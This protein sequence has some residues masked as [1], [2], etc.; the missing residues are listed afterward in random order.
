MRHRHARP[1][2]AAI[3][4][5]HSGLWLFA[6][7]FF[8]KPGG[9]GRGIRG[10]QASYS[11]PPNA[12]ACPA[13]GSKPG[14][15]MPRLVEE[16][17][18]GPID[19]VGDVHGEIGALCQL[20][21]R[22]GYDGNGDHPD[23]RRLVFLGDLVDRGPNSPAVVQVVRR[24]ISRGVAQMVLGNHELNLMRLDRK[25]GNKWFW[26]QTEQLCNKD[27]DATVPIARPGAP[28]F[29]V[30]EEESA[31]EGYIEFFRSLPLVLRRPG[32]AVVHAMYHE[33]SVRLVEAAGDVD[34]ATLHDEYIEHTQKKV[35]ELRANGTELSHDDIEMIWQNENPVKVLTTGMEEPAPE[36]FFAGGKMRTLTRSP[37]WRAYDGKAGL[38]VIGH[39]WRR[40]HGGVDIGILPTGPTIFPEEVDTEGAEFATLGP[41]LE[42]PPPECSWGAGEH[43]S[44]ACV[45]YSAGLRFEERGRDLMEG[46]LGTALA[47]LRMPEGTLHFADGSIAR[48]DDL[49]TVQ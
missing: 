40:R 48:L 24:F 45:D 4:C 20:L 44:V 37:W 41:P 15:P 14:Y 13:R 22:L 5:A 49:S 3:T 26:G 47:A 30:L 7:T 12:D 6:A 36:P 35:E 16:L 28:S 21:F 46:A 9:G 17:F 34:A 42:E 10:V 19:I 2:L 33:E 32:L 43:N 23:G 1:A 27:P 8:Y 11:C 18:D 39:F 38:V 29:Q 31:Q 25:H